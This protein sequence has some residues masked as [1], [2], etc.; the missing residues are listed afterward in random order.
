MA[1]ANGP[2]GEVSAKLLLDMWSDVL[3]LNDF[4]RSSTGQMA[5]RLLRSRLR[6]VWP[7]VRGETVLG[8][9]YAVALRNL[10]GADPAVVEET[11]KLMTELGTLEFSIV[12]NRTDHRDIIE[13]GLKT[14]GTD[15]I[16]SESMPPVHDSATASVLPRIS[17]K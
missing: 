15:V 13:L 17:R 14:P 11:K 4:Y 5:V 9:G 12:C 8:L 7:N 2:P 3:D 16:R 1:A 6:E 10:Q